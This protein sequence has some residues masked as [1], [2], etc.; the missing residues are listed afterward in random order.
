MELLQET[1]DITRKS[2]FSHVF[3]MTEESNAEILNV[4]QYSTMGVIP[5][6]VLN[7]FIHRFIPEADPEKSSLEILFEIFM[8]LVVMFCGVI[9]IHRVINYIPTYSGFKYESLNLT[10]VILAFLI[11]VLSIQT[12][13]GIKVNILVD[14]ALELWNGPDHKKDGTKEKVRTRHPITSHAPS[15]ADYLDDSAIQRGAFPPAPVATTHHNSVMGSY[16]HMMKPKARTEMN[17]GMMNMGPAA[18]N[19]VLGGAFGSAF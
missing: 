17:G 16:D 18:A 5:V 9:L 11:I 2:F 13:L 4:I 1:A 14:R 6:V 12:K 3:S 15:Q 7:K 19:G 8:Q 10:N